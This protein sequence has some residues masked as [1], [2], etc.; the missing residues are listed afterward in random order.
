MLNKQG[1]GKIEWTSW[2]WNPIS[3]CTHN[4]DFCYLKRIHGFDM[5]PKFHPERLKDIEKLK[6]PSRIFTG[7]SGDMMGD[8]LPHEQIQAV[9]EVMEAHPQHIFQILTKNPKRY[10]EFHFPKNVWLGTSVDGKR[11]IDNISWLRQ[12]QDN[13]LFVSFEPLL[14]EVHPILTGI[15]WIII[16]GKTGKPPFYPPKEWIETILAEAMKHEIAVFVKNNAKFAP[17]I[18]GFPEERL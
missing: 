14:E 18:K 3:G 5:T 12:K 6:E 1:K 7:S 13:L 9:I 2:T 15:N 8:W 10:V 11:N 17:I 16:G 4:C